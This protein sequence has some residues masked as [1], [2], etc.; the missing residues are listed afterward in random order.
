MVDFFR[1]TEF[2]EKILKDK[3]SEEQKSVM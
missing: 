2:F 3:S 1:K